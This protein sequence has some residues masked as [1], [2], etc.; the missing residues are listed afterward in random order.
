MQPAYAILK[1][2]LAHSRMSFSERL[3]CRGI[4]GRS[5]TS[6]RSARFSWIRFSASFKSAKPVRRVS[7]ACESP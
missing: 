6:N 1:V 7:N 3:L 5:R 4:S 2:P